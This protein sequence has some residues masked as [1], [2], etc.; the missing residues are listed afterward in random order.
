LVSE[1]RA[2]LALVEVAESLF[3]RYVVV[4]NPDPKRPNIKRIKMRWISSIE[5]LTGEG[6]VSLRFS[7]DILPYLSELKGQFTRYE[8][9]HIG[10]M[11]SIYAIRLYELLMQW[12]STGV[13]EVEIDW[14]KTV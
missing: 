4:D 11:T 9:K 2:Y 13:R 8:L 6:K 5:Y 12:K 14:L 3:N 10:N 1:K 7:Q